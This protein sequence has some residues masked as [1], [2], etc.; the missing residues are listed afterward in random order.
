M[1]SEL[2]LLN[3]LTTQLESIEDSNVKAAL[4]TIKSIL[5]SLTKQRIRYN[6]PRLQTH[7][8]KL[9]IE[10]P[11][12]PTPTIEHKEEEKKEET[13][14]VKEEKVEEKKEEMNEIDQEIKDEEE[15]FR[16]EMRREAFNED[17]QLRDLGKSMETFQ[18]WSGCLN[19]EIVFDSEKDDAEKNE[20]FYEKIFMKNNCY[21]VNFDKKGNVFGAYINEY[22]GLFDENI[23]DEKHFVFSLKKDKQLNVK[24]WF[25]KKE[26]EGGLKLFTN[27]DCL[28]QIGNDAC[29][30]FGI[31]KMNLRRNVCANL[32]QMYDGMND[33]DL[34]GSNLKFFSVER[35]VVIQMSE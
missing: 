16:Q 20:S 3:T 4:E 34:C 19:C 21:F 29:G 10:V 22:I 17:D 33:N 1:N 2:E 13:K 24:R 23:D 31:S 35:I 11:K 6:S 26:K 5:E 15:K 25:M 12:E 8:P 7:Q 32:S 27:N 28:Y 30:C 18:K 14:E 9:T